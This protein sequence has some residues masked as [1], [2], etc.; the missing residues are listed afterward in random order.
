MSARTLKFL[1][2]PSSKSGGLDFQNFEFGHL[3]ALTGKNLFQVFLKRKKIL[4]ILFVINCCER[5]EI[6]KFHNYFVYIKDLNQ[7]HIPIC[8]DIM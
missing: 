6:Y 2:R 1:L 5:K 4:N 7:F 3:L 8:V